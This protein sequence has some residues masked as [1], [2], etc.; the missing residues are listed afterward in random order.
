MT[1]H[2]HA[3]RC[4][5]C[6]L[7]CRLDEGVVSCDRSDRTVPSTGAT[8]V[9]LSVEHCPLRLQ[10]LRDSQPPP[11]SVADCDAAIEMA[12]RSVR[13]ATRITAIG[14]AL[15]VSAARALHQFCASTGA[16]LEL[17]GGSAAFDWIT[18]VQRNGGFLTTFAEVSERCDLTIVLGGDQLFEQYPRLPESL[19]PGETRP[20]TIVLLGQFSGDVAAHLERRLNDQR[21]PCVVARVEAS[22]SE[23]CRTLRRLATAPAA[24]KAIG[25]SPEQYLP[26]TVGLQA[27]QSRAI[28]LSPT[29][30]KSLG[31]QVFAAAI[32]F[33][34]HQSIERSTAI[35]P[36]GGTSTTLQ[37]TSTWLTGWP[38]RIHFDA[39]D[40]RYD[41]RLLGRTPIGEPDELEIHVSETNC[42]VGDFSGEESRRLK[43]IYV[44]CHPSE[45][46]GSD[47][48]LPVSRIGIEASGTLFRSD[49][50]VA[51][52]CPATTPREVPTATQF[53][54]L[55]A[56]DS[57]TSR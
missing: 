20:A 12:R 28:I 27:S 6:P 8:R 18:A 14:Y 22:P 55:L 13:Q 53:L 16:T 29:A 10:A 5:F 50:A 42:S 1:P 34:L 51:V 39:S 26:L 57:R 23:T 36:L 44:G 4:T 15:G 48:V 33:A 43:R 54:Q 52:R 35:L 37:Q 17:G 38:G 3:P 46:R 25:N 19:W 30:C 40:A 31:G 47:V 7:L 56:N 45:P 49:A 21:Q 2:S 41:P 24:A 9:W 11:S 32:E